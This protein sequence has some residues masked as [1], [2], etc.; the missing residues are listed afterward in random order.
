MGLRDMG[1]IGEPPR[2]GRGA[3]I[4]LRD[5]IQLF[6]NFT[7]LKILL[8]VSTKEEILAVILSPVLGQHDCHPVLDHLEKA[9]NVSDINLTCDVLDIL[10]MEL[11][12]LTM[13]VDKEVLNQVDDQEW[14][15]RYEFILWVNQQDVLIGKRK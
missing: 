1:L 15:E 5:S 4:S 9:I 7:S 2:L 11:E 13:L 6:D 14:F 12:E 10:E 8:K 3:I